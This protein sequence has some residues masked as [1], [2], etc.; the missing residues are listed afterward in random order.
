MIIRIADWVWLSVVGVGVDVGILGLSIMVPLAKTI[1][2]HILSWSKSIHWVGIGFVGEN[3]ATYATVDK[4][5]Q[6]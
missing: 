2:W 4:I 1:D 5:Q 6:E 3:S